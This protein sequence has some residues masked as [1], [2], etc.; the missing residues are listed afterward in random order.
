AREVL[1]LDQR[2][3]GPGHYYVGYDMASL[4]GLLYDAGHLEEAETLYHKA[5]TIYR[6]TLPQSHQYVAAALTGLARVF[7]ER[8]D[9][10]QVV[11]MTDRAIAIWRKE[12][13]EDHWQ[14]ANSRAVLG[15]SDMRSGKL[16]QAESILLA[17]YALLEKQRGV[18]DLN[19]R[20]TRRWLA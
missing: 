12:L 10:A 16:A 8:G 1:V 18:N 17:N 5:L 6:A 4:A 7:A 9:A 15:R 13:P 3:R 19:T 20:R 14:V 11:E 2:V